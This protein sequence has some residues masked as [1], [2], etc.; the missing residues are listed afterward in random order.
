M[1]P[2]SKRLK[3]LKSLT[4]LI[5]EIVDFDLEG[6]VWRGR[7]RVGDESQVPYIIIS[8]QPP[9]QDQRVGLDQAKMDWLIGI[10]GFIE[11]DEIHPSDTAHDLMA[12]VKSKLYEVV[13]DG[14]GR[15]SPGV[16]YML[17]GLITD[18]SHDGGMVFLPA[19]TTKS[20]IFGLKLTLT[21]S[22][23]LENLYED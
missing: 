21:L 14:G 11:G 7:N 3:I 17:N 10:H 22:E 1:M 5:E 16:N 12:A 9:E 23:T 19:E 4:T 8:E 15:G 2:D 18:L 6:K 20:C 13:D